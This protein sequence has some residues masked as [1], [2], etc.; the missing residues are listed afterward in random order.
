LAHPVRLRILRLL[1]FDELTN[2]EIAVHLEM[3]PATTLHHIR[4]LLKSGF[5]EP[6]VPRPGPNG[7]TEKPYRATVKSWTLEITDG[8]TRARA[9]A[10]AID[11]FATEIA[12]P[13]AKIEA[14]TRL[15]LNLSPENL[16]ELRQRLF[17]VFDEY[18]NRSDPGGDPYALF[19]AIHRRSKP[20]RPRSPK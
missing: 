16:T 6:G 10:A 5:I 11:A 2:A 14:M 3:N 12:E 19:L 13:G 17:D 8:P 7:I 4:T 1:R 9:G 18:E 15:T 20:R